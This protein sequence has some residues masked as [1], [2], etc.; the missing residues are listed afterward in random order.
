MIGW[1]AGF[2]II[3]MALVFVVTIITFLLGA[4]SRA[5]DI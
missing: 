4:A 2:E 1:A 5:A 3:A